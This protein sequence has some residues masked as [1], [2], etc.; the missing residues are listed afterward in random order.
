MNIVLLLRIL[1]P[2]NKIAITYKRLGCVHHRSLT[3]NRVL[4]L[5][6]LLHWWLSHC[7][8]T[9][10]ELGYLRMKV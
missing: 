5:H 1:D 3:L 9:G 7:L 6:V 10:E 2:G 4:N 8:V